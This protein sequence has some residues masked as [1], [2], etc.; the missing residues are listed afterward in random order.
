MYQWYLSDIEG[1]I[2]ENNLFGVDINE[3]SV[4]IA[5]Y[6]YGFAQHSLIVN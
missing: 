4:E 6:H 5:N 1:S 3:E 2:L